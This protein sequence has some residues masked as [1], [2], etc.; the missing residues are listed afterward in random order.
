[1]FVD[2]CEEVS[3]APTETQVVFDFNE[4]LSAMG[5][6]APAAGEGTSVTSFSQEGVTIT[7]YNSTNN[8]P[9]RIFLGTGESAKPDLRTYKGAALVITAPAGKNITKV[10]S[11]S[12]L[13][14]P[15]WMAKSVQ[16][17]RSTAPAPLLSTS[18]PVPLMMTP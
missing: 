3:A 2:A 14:P 10:S 16:P 5:L 13:H 4:G 8:T 7:A 17:L 18:L 9:V 12:T 1:M 15:S 6:S 11:I